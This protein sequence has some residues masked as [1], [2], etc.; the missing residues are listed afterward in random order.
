MENVNVWF[1]TK[2]ST[3]LQLVSWQLA[4]QKELPGKRFG[5]LHAE[6]PVSHNGRS[7]KKVE[8]PTD[9]TEPNIITYMTDML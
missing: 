4:M 2:N 3:L 1:K 6:K 7:N 9:Q 8:K 5:C